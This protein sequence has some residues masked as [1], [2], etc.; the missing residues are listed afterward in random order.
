[1]GVVDND[2]NA[3]LDVSSNVNS[4]LN[5]S[6]Q[7]VSISLDAVAL[8]FCVILLVL[9]LWCGLRVRRKISSIEKDLG[10]FIKFSKI[11]PHSQEDV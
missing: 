11:S 4:I 6:F 10:I 7:N 8:I 5:S 3:K 9:F 2:I 1:M